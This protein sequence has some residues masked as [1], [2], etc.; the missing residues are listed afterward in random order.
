M[1]WLFFSIL[2]AAAYAITNFIDKYLLETRVKDYQVMIIYSSIVAFIF[3]I[4]YWI[5][6]G[7]PSLDLK[8][9]I[10][11][12]ATGIL[13][14]IGLA[15]YFKVLAEEQTS[16]VIILM[17]MTPA[18]TLLLSVVFLGEKISNLQTFG[19]ILIFTSVI[20]TLLKKEHFHLRISNI[21][22]YILLTDFLWA[23]ANVIFKFVTITA[24]FSQ[25][26]GYESLGIALGGLLVYIFLPS[27]RKAFK[28]STKKHDI[29]TISFIILNEIIFIAA[30][31]LTF[32]AISIGPVTLV[33]IVGGTQ[34]FF[35][36]FYG[37]VLAIFAH[38]IFK[39]DMSL[40]ILVKKIILAIIGFLGIWLMQY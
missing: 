8:N 15:I 35:V 25:L 13:T 7:W 12:V 18:I 10:L 39:E 16:N 28:I 19:F 38:K 34:V 36:I 31:I 3:G 4:S 11:V 22:L 33:S 24:S 14:I 21:L 20:F 1:T 30:K 27:V 26:I 17:Q 9:S 40:Y 5:F 2:A 37:F 23:C 29:I 32:Y 6:A